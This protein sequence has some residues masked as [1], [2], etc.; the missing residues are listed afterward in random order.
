[1]H[2][3]STRKILLMWLRDARNPGQTLVCACI[4]APTDNEEGYCCGC[5]ILVW[6][7]CSQAVGYCD[8]FTCFDCRTAYHFDGGRVW[9]CLHHPELR[10]VGMEETF[11]SSDWS[12]LVCAP[13]NTDQ[14][15]SLAC[16][17]LT[18]QVKRV[19]F[20]VPLVQ[21]LIEYE[22]ESM[23]VSTSENARLARCRRK[24]LLPRVGFQGSSAEV[25]TACSSVARASP[26]VTTKSVARKKREEQALNRLPD[27]K[28]LAKG[29]PTAVTV[30]AI[31]AAVGPKRDRWKKALQAELAS[32]KEGTQGVL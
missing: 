27:V 13:C 16:L 10:R 11:G 19:R 7:H 8:H 1:M 3:L 25:S 17:S 32:L 6:Q 12:D 2:L 5:G 23:L 29:K 15:Q 20:D 24:G 18:E 31:R 9:A 26:I 14:V 21:Q 22:V 30:Q 28:D 4:A